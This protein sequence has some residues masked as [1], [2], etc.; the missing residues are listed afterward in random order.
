MI[1]VGVSAPGKT[2]MF[3]F[4]AKSTI[5][6]SKPVLVKNFTPASRAAACILDAENC[7][8]A[9]NQVR[10]AAHQF[11]YNITAPGTV[12]VT[13]MMGMPLL[14]SN[15]IQEGEQLRVALLHAV[16]VAAFESVP[17]VRRDA[18]DEVEIAVATAADAGA[19]LSG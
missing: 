6:R 3:C 16:D 17:A 13:S 8:G 9:N 15:S 5:S 19:A 14:V 7:T 1:S 18:N 11:G 10:A 4:R 2:K 12:M